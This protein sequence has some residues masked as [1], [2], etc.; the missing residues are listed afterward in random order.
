MFDL[1]ML[2][3]V[4]EGKICFSLWPPFCSISLELL[5]FQEFTAEEDL[6]NVA[7]K[8]EK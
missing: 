8:V 6:L 2:G 3:V 4:F 5:C 7:G 1:L